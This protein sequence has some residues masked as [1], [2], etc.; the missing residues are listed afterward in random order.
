MVGTRSGIGVLS[1][2]VWVAI[3]WVSIADQ[4]VSAAAQAAAPAQA[5]EQAQ[6]EKGRQA[7]GQA[8]AA[9][10]RNILRIIQIHRKSAEQ[11]RDTVFSMI[12]RG[13][14]ILP[15]EIEPLTA[16]LT[17]TAGPKQTSAAPAAQTAGNAART[18]APQ[19]PEGEARTILQRQCTRCHDLEAATRKPAAGDWKTVIARM[20]TYGAEVAPADQQKLIDYLNGL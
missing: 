5:G 15:E 2:T 4:R 3:L 14:Q 1:L 18:P 16:F 19:L 6:I 7:V 11:W 8:C 12:G 10:H 20:V 9:C 13:A 17:A